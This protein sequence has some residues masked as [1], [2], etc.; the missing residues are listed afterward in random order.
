MTEASQPEASKAYKV[1]RS[2][3]LRYTDGSIY[4][5]VVISP[6]VQLGDSVA[7]LLYGNGGRGEM[8]LSTLYQ[9]PAGSYT[10]LELR[11]SPKHVRFH[12]E[13]A[14]MIERLTMYLNDVDKSDPDQVQQV[15]YM[16]PVLEEAEKRY[17][18]DEARRFAPDLPR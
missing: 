2:D 1:E 9:D 4:V 6:A 12:G 3:I 14:I 17:Y 5:D 16:R 18:E 7:D 15:R 11:A 8:Q 10:H 13:L